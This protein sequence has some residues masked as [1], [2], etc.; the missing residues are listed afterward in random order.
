MATTTQTVI[1]NKDQLIRALDE[2]AEL[3]HGLMCLYLYAAFSLKKAGEPDTPPYAS[4]LTPA[5]AEITRRWHATIFKVARQEMEHLA[6][7]NNLRIGLGAPPYFR[8]P[9]FPVA[10]PYQPFDQ[11]MLLERFN[12]E[13][14]RHFMYFEQ[15]EVWTP[16]DCGPDPKIIGAQLNRRLQAVQATFRPS[17][18]AETNAPITSVQQLYDAIQKAINNVH[19]L[20]ALDNL[21][22]AGSAPHQPWQNLVFAQEANVF[23]F[24][25][26][27][28]STAN[29]AIDEI[30]KEGEG[31]YSQPGYASHFCSYSWIFD[32]LQS[33]D[34]DPAW[35]VMLSPTYDKMPNPAARAGAELID[36]A[37]VTMLYM[38]TSF[39]TYFT[40]EVEQPPGSGTLIPGPPPY[41]DLSSAL[42]NCAFAPMMTM[43]VRPLSE[44][45]TRIPSG[46]GRTTAGPAWLIPDQDKELPPNGDPTF[47]TDRLGRIVQMVGGL[48]SSAPPELR[49]RL[50]YIHQNVWRML[51]N[52][53]RTAGVALDAGQIE[54][55]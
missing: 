15:P 30:L 50:D 31:V 4:A 55:A 1:E 11:P 51:S 14:I 27:D 2:A 38:L 17:V 18:L 20:P 36:Y 34:F 16:G 54:P 39:Y 35:N 37:Y 19:H 25:V 8:R 23:A 13:S 9:N 26:Y 42:Q 24:P 52:F 45:L 43:V 12:V 7:V 28:V 53:A 40:P 21:F 6:L 32:E 46:D 3:E 49:P 41:G 48:R 33:A 47:F 44:I 22:V 10:Y 5:Q 29:A